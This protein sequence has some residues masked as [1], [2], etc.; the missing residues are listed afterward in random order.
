[1]ITDINKVVATIAADISVL[2]NAILKS[3][4]VFKT[5]EDP[6]KNADSHLVVNGV[7]THTL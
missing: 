6:S 4:F 7:G 5:G 2:V 3:L 1:V